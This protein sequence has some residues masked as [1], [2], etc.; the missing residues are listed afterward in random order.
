MTRTHTTVYYEPGRF[1]G[2]PANH[3]IWS[4]GDEIL[5]GFSRGYYQDRGDSHHIDHD[6]PEEHCLARSHDGGET[7]KIENPAER[8][9]LMPQGESLHGTE[10]PGVKI[11]PLRDCPGGIE[12]TQA[13]FALTART[14]SVN[15][16]QSRFSY[17]YDRGSTWEG[18]FRLPSYDTPGVAA[19]TD[20]IVDGPSECTLFLTAA[21]SSGK[22]GRP[23]C[24]RTVDGG[25]T[26][27]FLSWIGPEP[28]GFAIMPASVRLS[29]TDIIVIVRSHEGTRNWLSAYLSR[30]NGL[31][32]HWLN[33]P[34][35]DLGKGNPASLLALD[36]GR[37]CLIYGLRAEPFSMCAQVSDDDGQ[38][39]GDVIV[40]RDDGASQ[41]IGYP[42]SVSRPDGKVVTVYYFCHAATG[43]ERYIAATTW[44]P[45]S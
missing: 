44:D 23:F 45:C 25:A 38:S 11:P 27:S 20:Y 4:W 42:R 10:L 28:D 22:E 36:D 9:F 37:L 39:W 33:D 34:A 31:N 5:V 18:P 13:G 35:G 16:G 21:K 41:D 30:D 40:L 1:G 3:G 6:R 12:F 2:W 14:S 29:D 17:S 32:W 7:W 19:R 8:G 24:A 43:P 15:A 26:W